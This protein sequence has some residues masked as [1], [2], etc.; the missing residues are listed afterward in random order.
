MRHSFERLIAIDEK[1]SSK[2]ALE[3]PPKAL[4]VFLK[5]ISHSCDSWYWMLGLVLLWGLSGH[6]GKTIAVTTAFVTGTLAFLVLAIKFLFRRKRP[7]GE[8]GQVYRV[9]DPHSFPSGHAARAGAIAMVAIHFL[10]WW[11]VILVVLWALL[12]AYS[13]VALKVHYFSDVI[14][15]FTF[16]FFYAFGAIQI[17]QLLA[18]FFPGVANILFNGF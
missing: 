13:R 2:L 3:N 7:E 14:V 15:G 17:V 6:T 16:G 1:L 12:V 4:E 18:H 10:D 11:A 5:V 9:N 8:W